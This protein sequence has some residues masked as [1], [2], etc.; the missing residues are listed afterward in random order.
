MKEKKK[1]RRYARFLLVSF[2]AKIL[3]IF[4]DIRF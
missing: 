1:K 3:A 2:G 4:M